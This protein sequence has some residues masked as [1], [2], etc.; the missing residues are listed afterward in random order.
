MGD[1]YVLTKVLK[2]GFGTQKTKTKNW[3]KRRYIKLSNKNYSSS[4]PVKP[5]QRPPT[6]IKPEKTDYCEK[7]ILDLGFP[8]IIIKLTIK[9]I[10]QLIRYKNSNH[11]LVI[12]EKRFE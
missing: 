11:L 12:L 5:Y 8:N 6:T 4:S 9:L 7:K 3:L 1:P 10:F 2:G